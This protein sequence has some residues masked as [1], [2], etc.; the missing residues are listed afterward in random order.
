MRVESIRP[1]GGFFK[2]YGQESRRFLSMLTP[3]HPLGRLFF[4]PVKMV[5]ALWFRLFV[6]LA[7]HFLDRLDR[8]PAFTAGYFV[9]GRKD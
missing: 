4:L 7:C 1:N 5:F 8:D 9:S 3:T 6:P 2:L